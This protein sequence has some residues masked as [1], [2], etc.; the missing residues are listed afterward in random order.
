MK[1]TTPTYK[2]LLFCLGV[3]T[4]CVPAKEF[5]ALQDKNAKCEEERDK[6]SIE[7]ESLSTKNSELESKTRILQSKVETLTADSLNRAVEFN[8]I[9][10]ELKT[11]QERYT[12]LKNLQDGVISGSKDETRKL[13]VQIQKTQEELQEKEDALKELERRLYQRKLGLDKVQADLDQMKKELEERNARLIELERMLNAKDSI[14]Q[15]LRK[16]VADALFGFEGKGLTVSIQNGKV[17]VSLEEKLMF[18]SGSYEIDS[19]G[20]TALRQLVPVLEQNPDINIMVE[21]HTDDVPYRGTGALIDNWD[22]S[23]KRAT[24]I[25]RLLLKNSKID[26][27]RV[28]A[29]GRSQYLPIDKAKTPEARQKNRRTEIILTPKMDEILQLLEAN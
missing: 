1:L 26:P 16:R 14:M 3:L 5:Q 28:T 29:A 7:N 19:K 10:E 23:V 4:S 9:K 11:L 22:L 25:V 21:G 12:E 15:A 8:R 24:T 6:L 17:Y 13:L 2:I 27:V 20:A 18:K